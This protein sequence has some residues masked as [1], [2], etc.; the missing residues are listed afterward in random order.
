M[1]VEQEFPVHSLMR[2]ENQI[3]AKHIFIDLKQNFVNIFFFQLK[4]CYEKLKT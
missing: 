4:K 3:Q 1:H 2:I